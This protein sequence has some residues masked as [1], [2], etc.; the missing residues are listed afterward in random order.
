MMSEVKF[1]PAD[2]R[3]HLEESR[4]RAVALGDGLEP[5][6]S[7]RVALSFGHPA[8]LYILLQ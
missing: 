3:A 7:S 5:A 6:A 2:V 4:V 1:N 8:T